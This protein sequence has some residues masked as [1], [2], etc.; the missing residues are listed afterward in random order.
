MASLWTSLMW[1]HVKSSIT[2]GSSERDYLYSCRRLLS[3]STKMKRRSSTV[4]FWSLSS[5]ENFFAGGQRAVRPDLVSQNSPLGDIH[6]CLLKKKHP[7]TPSSYSYFLEDF[8]WDLI[9]WKRWESSHPWLLPAHSLFLIQRNVS[10][11][12]IQLRICGERVS[13]RSRAAKK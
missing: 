12:F 7:P 13:L 2:P 5:E 11:D 4:W 9:R 6:I 1:S 3:P 8:C 10:E